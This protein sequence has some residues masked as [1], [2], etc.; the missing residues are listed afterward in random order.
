MKTYTC[1]SFFLDNFTAVVFFSSPLHSYSALP[2]SSSDVPADCWEESRETSGDDLIS[3]SEEEEEEK[4]GSIGLDVHLPMLV[5]PMYSMLPVDQQA[6]VR[7]WHKLVD[8][9]TS[10]KI[11]L[12]LSCMST[13]YFKT[14]VLVEK[15]LLKPQ[16]QNWFLLV[17]ERLTHPQVYPFHVCVWQRDWGWANMFIVQSLLQHAM[18]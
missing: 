16:C 18:L 3:S 11:R 5:L 13:Q 6:K 7:W 4:C 2:N 17:K 12:P 15:L 10:F 8:W 1:F 14:N 9:R